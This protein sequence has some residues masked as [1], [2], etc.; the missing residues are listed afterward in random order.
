[1]AYDI[2]RSCLHD[3][4]HGPRLRKMARKVVG[5]GQGIRRQ[6]RQ[7]D[8]IETTAGRCLFNDILPKMP[9]YNMTMA[10]EARAA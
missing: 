7:A 8:V 10:E 1:M 2:G 9:F 5:E 3:E 4:D 6:G